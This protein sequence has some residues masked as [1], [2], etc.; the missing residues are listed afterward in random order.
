VLVILIAVTGMRISEALA[1]PWDCINRKRGR[2]HIIRKWNGEGYGAPKSKMSAKPVEMTQGLATVLQTW[3]TQTMYAKDEHLL[4]PSYRLGGK[5]PRLGGMLVEDH[6]RP[7]A[8][9]AGVLET[10]NGPAFYDGELVVRFG[11]H[12]LRHGLATWLAEKGTNPA[13]IRRM[14]RHSSTD[15]T[16]HYINPKAREA[17][18]AIHRGT[19]NCGY[20]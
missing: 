9:A 12:N 16:M 2:I 17:P 15:M 6:L 14:L 1:L 11:F 18:G 13:V 8:V 7:A 4:F 3:R 10:R 20:G 19:G 5:Q